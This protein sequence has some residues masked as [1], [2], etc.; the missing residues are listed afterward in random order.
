MITKSA[1]RNI[2]SNFTGES[3][4]FGMDLNGKAFRI[5][6]DGIYSDKIR[7]P[8]REYMTNAFD[9]HVQ[10]GCPELPFDVDVPTILNPTLR[11]RDYGPGMSH[12]TVMDLYSTMF[13]STKGDSND[14]VGAFGLGSKSAFAYTDTFNVTSY[15]NGYKRAYLAVI[16]ADDIPT[17]TEIPELSGF[18]NEPSGFEVSIP[19]KVDDISTFT[20]AVIAISVG[21]DVRPN[22]NIDVPEIPFIIK[23]DGW[24]MFRNSGTPLREKLYVRQGCVLY[25]VTPYDA[26]QGSGLGRLNYGTSVIVDVPIGSCEVAVSREAL[27]YDARTRQNVVA[28]FDG[29]MDKLKAELQRRINDATTMLEAIR[30]RN[31]AEGTLWGSTK[32]MLWNGKVIPVML[33]PKATVY[34]IKGRGYITP[35]N[36]NA[37]NPS[38]SHTF[39]VDRGEKMLRRTLRLNQYRG[40]AYVVIDPSN[41]DLKR[42]MDVFGGRI[43][44]IVN[45]PD[46]APKSRTVGD[47]NGVKPTGVYNLDKMRYTAG[48]VPKFDYW[49]PLTAGNSIS[50]RYALAGSVRPENAKNALMDVA[51]A[52]GATGTVVMLTPK[53]RK[54]YEVDDSTRWDLVIQKKLKESVDT[55]ADV[56]YN[57]TMRQAA[58]SKQVEFLFSEIGVYRPVTPE[59]RAFEAFSNYLLTRYGFSDTLETSTSKAEA[60]LAELRQ[61][62]PVLFGEWDEASMR[63]YINTQRKDKA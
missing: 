40:N 11:I 58:T 7:T 19:V 30:A 54:D 5:L 18:T 12:A 52:V 43:I 9:A 42:L 38:K 55:I 13:R 20:E 36:N 35:I 63:T 31:D 15:H 10:G 53:A 28:A 50:E 57:R 27:A 37:L 22:F 49:L 2:E 32:D 44:S 56:V 33:K 8:I 48:S 26:Q 41:R 23:G 4:K 60:K 62:Y 39:I 25:P 47:G 24:R 29:V 34:E 59:M 16:G 6:F 51:K 1:T 17:I 61:T 14:E 21:F 46:V 45:L 3:R